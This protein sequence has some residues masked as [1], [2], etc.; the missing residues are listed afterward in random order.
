M[1]PHPPTRDLTRL[2]AYWILGVGQLAIG[3][4]ALLARFGLDAGFNP[5]ALA[6]WR[7][8]LAALIVLIGLAVASRFH[9]G[10]APTRVPGGRLGLAGVLLGLHFATWFASLQRTPVALSTLLVCTTPVWT[11]LGGRIF[12]RQ[13]VGARFWAGLAIA[14]LG[15]RVVTLTSAETPLPIP[16]QQAAGAILALLGAIFIAAYLLMIQQ[17]TAHSSGEE[18]STWRLVAWTYSS[19]AI[20]LWPFA[21][22]T[23]RLSEV[24]PASSVV[25]LSALGMAVVPQIMGHTVINWSLRHLPASQVAATILV[26]P[27]FAAVLAWVFL[28]EKMRPDQGI[29]GLILLAGVALALRDNPGAVPEEPL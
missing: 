7:L 1:T 24:V 6:A 18:V 22:G 2:T 3:S 5:V 14:A 17:L 25:W 16:G 20:A 9:D 28:G 27:V 10:A 19:G 8:T 29:G 26:E 21:L 23:V 15:M 4:A 12:L 13:R 11:G